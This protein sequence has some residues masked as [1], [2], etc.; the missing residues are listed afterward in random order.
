MIGDC[1]TP[2]DYQVEKVRRSLEPFEKFVYATDLWRHD[3][4][5]ERWLTVP[6]PNSI[7]YLEGFT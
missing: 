4:Q 5:F 1:K 3:V 7:F 6:I 2:R